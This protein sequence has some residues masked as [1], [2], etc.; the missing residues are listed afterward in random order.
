MKLIFLI[1]H[2]MNDK[3]RS[4]TFFR[5]DAVY[6]VRLDSFEL[7]IMFIFLILMCTEIILSN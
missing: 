7:R 2:I 4:E 3:A 1:K 6:F 5:E